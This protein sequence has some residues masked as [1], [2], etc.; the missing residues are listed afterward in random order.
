MA[1]H[2]EKHRIASHTC[3]EAVFFEWVEASPFLGHILKRKRAFAFIFFAKVIWGYGWNWATQKN[4]FGAT[5]IL[6]PTDITLI[7]WSYTLS[8]RKEECI[9]DNDSD[10]WWFET[11]LIFSRAYFLMAARLAANRCLARKP[12][13]VFWT[14]TTF[15]L[16]SSIWLLRISCCQNLRK[17]WRTDKRNPDF[18]SSCERSHIACKKK[19]SPEF[20][21]D[22]STS[23]QNIINIYWPTA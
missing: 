19:A 9:N 23:F 17:T 20:L 3:W 2:L 12:L 22:V 15:F 21:N 10:G 4:L 18:T 11:N 16:I 5:S 14:T 6:P 7:P 8:Y 13:T 1:S